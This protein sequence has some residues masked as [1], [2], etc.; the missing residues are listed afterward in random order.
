[1]SGMAE[2]GGQS[3]EA[4][5]NG[6][7]PPPPRVQLDSLSAA[8]K[9]AAA[10][11]SAAAAVESPRNGIA[12]QEVAS[13][14]APTKTANF[15]DEA[16]APSAAATAASSESASEV[17]T[18]AC[19]AEPPAAAAAQQA[20]PTRLPPT[21]GPK[22]QPPAARARASSDA[23]ADL[24]VGAD[25]AAHGANDEQ[26]SE[27]SNTEAGNTAGTCGALVDLDG[28]GSS[29]ASMPAQAAVKL[30]DVGKRAPVE[31][32]EPA[33]AA[34]R[35]DTTSA[36]EP[37]KTPEQRSKYLDA[38]PEPLP[39]R[40]PNKCGLAF[41]T[42]RMHVMDHAHLSMRKDVIR[43][44]VQ[45]RGDGAIR[46]MHTLPDRDSHALVQDWAVEG[47]CQAQQEEGKKREALI[48]A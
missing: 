25:A 12:A 22:K 48:T 30:T 16:S 6:L 26:L 13:Q 9:P 21:D 28:G 45:V 38:A 18:E 44:A 33:N 5:T 7:K 24:S 46:R 1:M 8:N 14:P 20:G 19:R 2:C 10:S 34:A 31:A 29:S 40:A 32:A 42:C 3:V 35:D 27:V 37:I 43:T 39:K 17:I 23:S 11:E 47:G 36:V 41:R 15:S 4:A